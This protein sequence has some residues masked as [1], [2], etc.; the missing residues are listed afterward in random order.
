MRD[1]RDLARS[2]CL[3]ATA[4]SV[5]LATPATSQSLTS[6]DGTWEIAPESRPGDRPA[7]AAFVRTTVPGT[8][9]A[10]LG[11]DFDGVAWYRRTLH[12]EAPP[13]STRA[14]IECTAAATHATVYLDG[15]AIGSHLGG[16]TPFRC[17]IPAALR[18]EAREALLEVRLDERVGHNTQGFLPIIQPHFGGLWQGV[19]LRVDHGPTLDTHDI[20]CF[21]S[22]ADSTVHVDCGTLAHPTASASRVH[23]R[24]RAG[25]STLTEQTIDLDATGRARAEISVTP[26]AAWAPGSPFLHDVQLTLLD[27][28]GD[29]L[30]QL[31]RRVGF[32]DFAAVGRQLRWNGTPL[33]VRGILHWG[34]SPPQFAPIRTRA[35]WRAELEAVAAR[36]FNLVKCCLWVPPK[37][38]YELCDELGLLVWQEYPTWHPQL[39]PEHL[40]DLERE[41]EEFYRHDRSHPAVALRSLTCETGH[42]ADLSVLQRLYDRAHA[43]I[44]DTLIIDDSAWISWSRIGD[45]YDD[46]PYGNNTWWPGK[47]AE[48]DRFI[49]EREAKPLLLGECITS[50]TWTPDIA[51]LSD[52]WWKPWCLEAQTAFEQRLRAAHGDA[53]VARLAPDSLRG[54][55]RDRKFQIERLRRTLP[56]AGY[57]VS[58]IRDFP[59][60]R[61]GLFDDH[62]QPK[63]S[64]ADWAWHGDTMICLGQDAQSIGYGTVAID[65]VV[66]HYGHAP[67]HGALEVTLLDGDTRHRVE[68]APLELAPG[69][70]GP[71]QSARFDLGA[72]RTPRRVTL[73]AELGA[74]SN[75][76]DLWVLPP[77]PVTP[78]DHRVLNVDHLDLATLDALEAGADVLLRA[79]P[80]TGSLR[81]QSLWFLRG[82][83]VAPPH[84]VH[85]RIPAAMLRDLQTFDL[86]TGF[87]LPPGPWHDCATPILAFWDTHD[88]REVREHWLVFETR[89]GKG[90]LLVTSL[91]HSTPAGRTVLRAFAEHL[92]D[93]PA[94][95]H[96]AT[97]A[98]RARLRADLGATTVQ[99]ESWHFR[100]DPDDSG[101]DAGWASAAPDDDWRSLRAGS[102][103][104]SQG[105]EHVD[106][107]AWY[108]TTFTAPAHDADTPVHAVFDGVDDSFTLWIDGTEIG[109]W[110]DPESGETV[111]LQRISTD[112]TEHLEPGVSHRITLRVVDHGGAGGIWKPVYVTTGPVDGGGSLL[113]RPR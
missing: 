87:V 104:E 26:A 41:F 109:K 101:R 61:M 23:V 46:H 54:A 28:A 77:P 19:A 25:D 6:L 5:G 17:E 74:V 49:E 70:V 88:L 110:G 69:T 27:A 111:W 34:F 97:N 18:S 76:W 7:D 72:S 55:M 105:V 35:A 45:F 14:Y 66:S 10:A 22:L 57:V 37:A 4:L 90:R 50:D 58:V 62:D 106:G 83:P 12:L 71:S 32:R 85:R 78:P 96:T 89:F 1:R 94:P 47:L 30:D 80:R 81:T 39:T 113:H 15:V 16:W 38:F 52:A 29:T 79:G 9:E 75:T 82:K 56:D 102:H 3:A 59:K 64:T 24:V 31:H 44:P 60:A 36:G 107:V 86:E 92:V 63:W 40:P 8:F 108:T 91:D 13:A 103:W 100:V 43:L 65:L 68:L 53:T 33:A 84:P 112:V 99:L 93:G 67:L 98:L 51:S 11:H 42:S 20:H 95:T 48:F 21:G 73:Q 2:V